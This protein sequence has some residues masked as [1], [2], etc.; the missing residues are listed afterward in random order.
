MSI[1]SAGPAVASNPARLRP[2]LARL[3]RLHPELSLVGGPMNLVRALRWSGRGAWL[4]RIADHL[5]HGDARPA[6]V[7]TT[8]PLRV[9]AYSDELDAVVLLAGP[10]ALVAEL[11]LEPGRRLLAVNADHRPRR[12]GL[13]DDLVPGPG[14]TGRFGSFAPII[15]DFVS[16][17]RD[18]IAALVAALP[19][20]EWVRCALMAEEHDREHARRARWCCPLACDRQAGPWAEVEDPCREAWD[21]SP[22]NGAPIAR[23]DAPAS[24]PAPVAKPGGRSGRGHIVSAGEYASCSECRTVLFS[25][26]R[27][28]PRCGCRLEDA[29]PAP[30]AA[31][32]VAG[33]SAAPYARRGGGG[34]A[35][36]GVPLGERILGVTT[37]L[38][39][40]PA[41]Q[42]ARTATPA[43]GGGPTPGSVACC[44]VGL[45]LVVGTLL[46]MGKGR[47]LALVIMGLGLLFGTLLS[48]MIGVTSAQAGGLFFGLLIL[49]SAASIGLLV[50]P[51]FP[52]Q[53]VLCA[54]I[55]LLPFGLSFVGLKDPEAMLVLAGKLE[56]QPPGQVQLQACSI[57]VGAGWYRM[58][59][60]SSDG[61]G[62]LRGGAVVNLVTLTTD[63]A[64]LRS[65]REAGLDRVTSLLVTNNCQA[66]GFS[67]TAQREGPRPRSSGRSYYLDGTF[68]QHGDAPGR[69]LTAVVIGRS[70][71][72]TLNAFGSVQDMSAL[73]ASLDG[74]VASLEVHD[75]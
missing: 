12:D 37:L 54:A 23:A 31:A 24:A 63:P 7:V 33:P 8:E 32:P 11:G 59:G 64:R 47:T 29:A 9:A 66:L 74:V 48:I 10:Q 35:A 71:A 57:E 40:L 55:Q 25:R 30:V 13:L 18:R 46:V 70:G 68:V 69:L 16:D 4:E 61:I 75:P 3:R 36:A 45:A 43:P 15:A 52:G 27:T 72:Y 53:V 34:E 65:F 41:L 50:R 38:Y 58:M 1:A 62:L 28:C 73:A 42:S 14:D 26:P 22:P 6:L 2:S 67:P 56:R 49:G 5:A 19:E 44:S 21:R 17:D 60:E 39:V 20:A 51:R